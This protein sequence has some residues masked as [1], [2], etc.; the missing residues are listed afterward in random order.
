M[1]QT[2]NF[3]NAEAE[4]LN[5][6]LYEQPCPESSCID[7]L[8]EQMCDCGD[9]P[10]LHM[11][12]HE[13]CNGLGLA[14]PWAGA[15]CP[16]ITYQ[17]RTDGINH[18]IDE[19]PFG[20]DMCKPCYLYGHQDD[21]RCVSGRVPKAVGLSLI[22]VEAQKLGCYDTVADAV[23]EQVRSKWSTEG[24]ITLAAL[25]AYCASVQQ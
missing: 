16:C 6:W 7:G 18:A 23:A 1:T 8:L 22:V 9:G 13:A 11:K 17:G 4:E 15:E 19:P 21:C 5:R 14:F 12:K 25:R 10:D 3:A 24:E 2:I 20:F